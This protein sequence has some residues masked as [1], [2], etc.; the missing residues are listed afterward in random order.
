M[1]V[2]DFVIKFLEDKGIKNVFT[3]SGGG[4]IFLCDALYKSKK[5]N[6]VSCHHEQA[7]SFATESYSRVKNK[8]GAAIIT[9][10]PG[11]TNCTTGVACCWID[12]V[13]SI[14]I[15]GQ[16]YLNQTIKNTGLRQLGVQEFDIVSMVKTSTKYSVIIQTP[17]SIKY[18]LEKAYYLSMEGR[19][20]PVWVD[21][22]ANIQNAI[23]NPKKLVGYKINKKKLIHN[24]I[25][26]NKNNI[27]YILTF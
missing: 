7:V 23:I 26:G 9:T 2:A 24:Q 22:P 12:S 18:H 20:G 10:G 14:F 17:E 15:S 6:Y 25:T 27:C 1:R 19:P 21:I 5:L 3:V 4:S 13:P 11:G 16:V 8:P